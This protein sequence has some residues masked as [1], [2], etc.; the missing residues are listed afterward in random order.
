MKAGPWW[1]VGWERKK[2]K[3]LKIVHYQKNS[4]LPTE[5]VLGVHPSE[6]TL[7]ARKG[8]LRLDTVSLHERV[9]SL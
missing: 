9:L 3:S 2:L 7:Q 4:S 6:H 5:A 1:A 8:E